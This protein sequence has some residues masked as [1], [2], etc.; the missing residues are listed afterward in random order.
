[1]TIPEPQLFPSIRLPRVTRRAL[2]SGL[3][4]AAVRRPGVPMVEIRLR[5]PIATRTMGDNGVKRVLARTLLSGT[6]RRDDGEIADEVQAAGGSLG[7]SADSDAVTISGSALRSHLP[8]LLAVV[9]DVLTGAA[10]PRARVRN[11][12][13]RLAQELVIKR[14]DPQTVVGDALARRMYPSHPYGLGLPTATALARAG[15]KAVRLLRD[16]SLHP[17]AASLVLVG[18]VAP[19]RAIDMAAVA[20]AGWRGGSGGNPVPAPPGSATGP[21]TIIDRPGAVQTNIRLGARAP[22]RADPDYPALAL[23]ELVY[24]GYFG[25]RLSANVREDKGYSY[26]PTSGVR[27]RRSASTL[28]IAANV[29]SEVTGAALVE[30][31]YELGRITTLP[32]GEDELERARR[33]RSGVLMMSIQTQAGLAGQISRLAGAGLDE[34]YLRDLPKALGKVTTTD[35]LAAARV[36]LR[37]TSLAVLMLGDASRIRPQVEPLGEVEVVGR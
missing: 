32:I 28:T 9:G 13:D 15:S 1:M 33:Y 21:I 31:L 30:I 4:V 29:A 25:S 24:G 37:P 14:S 7:V 16:R 35:A 2:D 27:H 11:Q 22:M 10:F 36:W 19:A 34:R 5:I 8:D 23:A 17:A 3:A 18:D 20:L 26:S 6:T 12:R